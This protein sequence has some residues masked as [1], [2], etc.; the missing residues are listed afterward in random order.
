MAPVLFGASSPPV[1]L[2]I[3]TDHIRLA[4]VRQGSAGPQLT[5]Y[6][7]VPM[8]LGAVVEGEIVDPVAV[9]GALK[10]LWRQSGVRTR[11]VAVGISNH[12]VV[13]RL[14][15]L[16]FMERDELAGVIQYQA[17]DYIPI[18]VDEA[19]IDFHV[20]DDYVAAPSL[21]EYASSGEDHM[22]D[23]MLVAAERDMIASLVAAM[24]GAGLK[25]AQVD[26]A[27]FALARA[28]F[29]PAPVLFDEAEEAGAAVGVV[30][31]SSGITNIAVVAKGIPR[32][33]RVSSL[34]SSQ[35]TQ[36]LANRFTLT[37]DEA[38]DLKMS[39]GLPDTEAP[40]PAERSEEEERIHA[41]QEVLER[42]AGKF[43]TE[44]R[45]SL[46]YC[47]TQVSQV[48]TI[49]RIV[50]SGVG[51][52]IPR[53]AAY[54]EKG[55]QTQVVIGDPLAFVSASGAVEQAVLADRAGSAL[56]IGLA[57]GGVS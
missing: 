27:A 18:P 56:A 32:F 28:L 29:G 33:T 55:L 45:R 51:A 39:A 10:D 54:L 13:V 50:L 35:F 11:E 41:A 37:F 25:P 5:A 26:V 49:N 57:L 40:E 20:I 19:I 12:K 44:V 43:I 2:D 1:G 7:S 38:E 3:G 42:E 36:A 53:L 6:A 22:M 24:E 47:L 4:Q 46:D 48:Q 14:I 31:I 30:H 9:T 34:A 15:E 16:P 17:Q 8:P 21:E 52:E 23:V